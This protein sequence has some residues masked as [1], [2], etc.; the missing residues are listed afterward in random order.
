MDEMPTLEGFAIDAS[1]Q[2]SY[3]LHGPIPVALDEQRHQVVRWGGFRI[4][5]S[6]VSLG[7]AGVLRYQGLAHHGPLLL[8]FLRYSQYEIRILKRSKSPYTA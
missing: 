5:E 6:K 4:S 8:V 2:D 7:P 3:T 1:Q